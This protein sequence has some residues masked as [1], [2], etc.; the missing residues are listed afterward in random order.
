MSSNYVDDDFD[1]E[2][3]DSSP[4]SLR[5]A[6]N[7]A[8]KLRREVDGLRRE[9]AFA[10][11]GLPMNDPKMSYFIKGYDGDLDAEA[12]KEAAEAAGFLEIQ[13]SQAAQEKAPEPQQIAQ[14]ALAGQE[15]VIAAAAGAVA[16]DVTEAAA[17]ARMEQAMQEGGIEALM[18][19]ARAYGMPTAYDG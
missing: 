19:V 3:E 4:A 13:Q 6:A 14:Q 10:K 12:I 8:K 17:F 2:D 1:S 16:E 9:L 5:R 18:D 7:Q 11:A 15:R